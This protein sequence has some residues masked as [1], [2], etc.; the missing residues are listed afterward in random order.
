MN[1]T[2]K[3]VATI[4]QL[5]HREAMALAAAEYD[6]F[7]TAVHALAADD[8]DRPTDNDLWDVKAMVAHVLGMME[9][10]A[11]VSEMVR[12]QRAA[13]KASKRNHTAMIDELTA[14]QVDKH[15]HRPV[16]E[17]TNLVRTTAPKALAG[18]R[19]PPRFIS[20]LPMDPGTPLF[21]EKWKLGYLLDVIL[22]RDTS[23]CFSAKPPVGLPL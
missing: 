23:G 14:L 7:V 11:A 1:I 8:W 20:A 4:P 2:A 12:Q 16:A 15:V 19:R 17:L 13:A 3:E 22:T 10:N 9:M 5:G 6:R 18:R 21:A